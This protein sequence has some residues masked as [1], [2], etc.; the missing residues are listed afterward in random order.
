MIKIIQNNKLLEN[1]RKKMKNSENKN[2]YIN[3][4]NIVEEFFKNE[5]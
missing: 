1:M 5:N 4:E 2:V 3:I